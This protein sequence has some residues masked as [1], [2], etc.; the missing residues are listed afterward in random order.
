MF[1]VV[2]EMPEKKT[3]DMK[4]LSSESVE[5]NHQYH[6]IWWVCEH[7]IRLQAFLEREPKVFFDAGQ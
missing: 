6:I 3:T 1:C 4:L 2:R 5:C 7:E